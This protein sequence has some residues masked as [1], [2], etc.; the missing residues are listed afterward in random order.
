MSQQI[1]LFN[2]IFLK[3][4]KIFSAAAMA[5][6]L[7]VLLVGVLAVAL[8]AR[9]NVAALQREAD[10]GRERLAQREARL[11]KVKIDFAP[12]QKSVELDEQ[13][14]QA[15]ARL[16]AL[17]DVAG[18]LERGELGNTAGYAAYFKALARQNLAGVWLTGVSISGAGTDL[19]VQGRALD[20]AL[21]PAYLGRLTREPV[22]RGKSFASLR[23]GQP[24]PGKDAAVAP[25]VEFS[26]GAAPAEATP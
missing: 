1:N 21:V 22:M 23:I 10:S 20:A 15:E 3:Q 14:V 9:Q 16:Q 12:R 18:V 24:A 8:Y 2:P 19:G 25:Y 13:L 26:V 5:Q 6:A 17:R 7:C 4:K 11:A